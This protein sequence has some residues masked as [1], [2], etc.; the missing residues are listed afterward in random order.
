MLQKINDV[1]LKLLSHLNTEDTYKF[2]VEEAERLVKAKHGSIFLA[3][4]NSL[5]RVY[6]SNT[7]L[8]SIQARKKGYTYSAFKERKLFILNENDVETI[9]PKLIDMGIKSV[10]MVPLSY[11]KKSIGVLTLQLTKELQQDDEL[12]AF[13]K[14]FGAMASLKI[15][16]SQLLTQTK[17]AVELRD[18]F[19]SLAS[20]ELRTPMTTVFGYAQLLE[21]KHKDSDLAKKLVEECKRLNNLISELL[22]INQIKT[23]K[24]QYNI[25]DLDINKVVDKAIQYFKFAYPKHKIKFSNKLEE[26]KTK[27]LADEDKLTQVLTNILN[28]AQKFSPQ[29]EPIQIKLFTERGKINITIQDF[30]EGI[31]PEDLPHIFKGFY[32]GKSSNK[33]GMGLGLFL[34]KEI[35]TKHHGQLTIKSEKQKGTTVKIKLPFIR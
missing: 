7:E 17:E 24:L 29:S 32:K 22:E 19:I 4:N 18:L 35:I 20:H 8:N 23:G 12:L 34:A 11:H 10:V 6:S 28:N 13:L 25:Q 2:I 21:R 1:A 3:K 31:D 26:G 14:I 16:N 15:R 9:H 27:L 5:R 33:Q 30:G